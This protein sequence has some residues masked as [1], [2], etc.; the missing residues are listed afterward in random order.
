MLL[1]KISSNLDVNANEIRNPL[2]TTL[3][4]STNGGGLLSRSSYNLEEE[5]NSNEVGLIA[6]AAIIIVLGLIAIV[7]L[8]F[9]WSR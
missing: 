6:L 3:V 2:A 1:S 7:Y 8:C 4:K 5:L 9:Q